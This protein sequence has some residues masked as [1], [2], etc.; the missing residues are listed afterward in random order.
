MGHAAGD[1]QARERSAPERGRRDDR[2]RG[3]RS[4]DAHQ[5]AHRGRPAR[6]ETGAS[7]RAGESR[8]PAAVPPAALDGRWRAGQRRGA[9]SPSVGVFGT[10]P[11]T[12][13]PMRTVSRYPASERLRSSGPRT[14]RCWYRARGRSP[15]RQAAPAVADLHERAA[16]KRAVGDA[17]DGGR[18]RLPA[19][20]CP[21]VEARAEPGGERARGAPCEA[22]PC[23]SPEPGSR[24][25]RCRRARRRAVSQR[26]RRRRR[27]GRARSCLCGSCA[28]SRFAY[29][30]S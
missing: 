3:R 29:G 30:V 14:L 9:G 17:D 4:G 10:L 8:Q 21:A 13:A 23:S 26:A 1:P 24:P 15:E 11:T 2:I 12:R 16:R 19:G 7:A 18:Q 20:G 25:R 22:Q 6:A 5:P 28:S 27:A